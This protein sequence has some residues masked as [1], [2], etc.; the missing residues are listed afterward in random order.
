[1]EKQ[2]V[3]AVTHIGKMYKVKLKLPTP[4]LEVFKNKVKNIIKS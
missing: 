2:R 4:D 3:M 1:V